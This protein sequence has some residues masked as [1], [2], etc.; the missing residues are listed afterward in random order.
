MEVAL[1]QFDQIFAVLK[2]D[3]RGKMQPIAEWA[4]IEGREKDVGPELLEILGS[5]ALSDEQV[6]QK[7][8]EMEAAR[9][10]KNFKVSDAIR[11]EL[12]AAGIIVEQTKDGVRW[13][14][15]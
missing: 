5:A 7:V 15:K 4:R 1:N 2:D 10:A 14:R 6:N 13:R 8:A 11:A 3:D 9:K 12:A